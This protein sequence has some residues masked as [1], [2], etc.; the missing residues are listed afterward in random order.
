MCIH[1]HIHTYT[2]TL[3]AYLFSFASN[4]QEAAFAKSIA[5]EVGGEWRYFLSKVSGEESIEHPLR[6]L[7]LDFLGASLSNILIPVR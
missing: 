7:G 5:I 4:Y 6:I 2:Y 3:Y 1:I